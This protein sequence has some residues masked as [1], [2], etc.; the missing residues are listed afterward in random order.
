[1]LENYLLRAEEIKYL[2]SIRYEATSERITGWCL[3]DVT[4]MTA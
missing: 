4:F 1:M 3:T 2:S